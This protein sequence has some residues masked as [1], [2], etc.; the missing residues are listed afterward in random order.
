M[1]FESNSH[2]VVSVFLSYLEVQSLS[3]SV[4]DVR[5]GRISYGRTGGGSDK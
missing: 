3:S 5:S 2:N 1:D 4:L